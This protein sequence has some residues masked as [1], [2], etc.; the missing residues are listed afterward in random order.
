[1]GQIPSIQGYLNLWST[2]GN[3]VTAARRNDRDFE[4]EC[5]NGSSSYQDLELLQ[6][7]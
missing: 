4:S 6:K 2:F 3:G 1:L 5:Q 7:V